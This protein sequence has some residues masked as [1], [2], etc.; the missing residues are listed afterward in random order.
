MNIDTF[1]LLLWF[2]FFILFTERYLHN[3][4]TMWVMEDKT[5]LLSKSFFEDNMK[6]KSIYYITLLICLFSAK[7]LLLLLSFHHSWAGRHFLLRHNRRTVI[8]THPLWT[9]AQWW[10]N[11]QTNWSCA[12]TINQQPTQHVN[13]ILKHIYWVLDFT[14]YGT[15]YSHDI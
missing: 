15:K 4:L 8:W 9:F 2:L 11:Q 7:C 14:C 6:H 12:W 5:G 13:T 10:P 1:V 3:A